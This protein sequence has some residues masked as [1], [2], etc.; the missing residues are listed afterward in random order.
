MIAKLISLIYTYTGKPQISAGY[1][2]KLATIKS[3][4]ADV[5][6]VSPSSQQL[7]TNVAPVQYWNPF[8]LTSAHLSEYISLF[9]Q[10]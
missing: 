3:V 4:K 10:W 9:F 7:V 8:Q 2:F 5:S 6:S 1:L